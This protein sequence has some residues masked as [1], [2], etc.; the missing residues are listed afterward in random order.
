MTLEP[1][2]QQNSSKKQPSIATA[3]NVANNLQDYGKKG[4]E[5]GIKN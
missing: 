5:V 4:D 1:R 3:E 2:N